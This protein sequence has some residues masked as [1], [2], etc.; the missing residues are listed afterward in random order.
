MKKLFLLLFVWTTSQAQTIWPSDTTPCNGS[1]SDC[2][3][4]SGDFGL[5]E[6]RT[7]DTINESIIAYNGISLI[8]GQG[9]KPHFG[10]GHSVEVSGNSGGVNRTVRFEGLRFSKGRIAYTTSNNGGS[11]NLII[12]DN[13]I[14]DNRYQ[15]TGIRIILSGA[16]TMNLDVSNNTI[17]FNTDEPVNHSGAISITNTF[18][19]TGVGTITG[20]VRENDI[21]LSGSTSVGIGV[22]ENL[23]F[24]SNLNIFANK[25]SGGAHG[26]YL[27]KPDTSTG[28]S[29]LNFGSNVMKRQSQAAFEANVEG[30]VLVLDV[31]NNTVVQSDQ[32]AFYIRSQNNADVDLNF[33]NN[34]AAFNQYPI[35]VSAT[36]SLAVDTQNGSNLFFGN[37]LSS[38]GFTPGTTHLTSDPQFYLDERIAQNS[39]AANTGNGLAVFFLPEVAKSIDADGS[40]RIKGTVDIGAYES[41]N[42]YFTHKVSGVPAHTNIIDSPVTNN[43]PNLKLQLTPNWNPNG[44]GGVYNNANQGVFYFSNHWRVFNQNLNSLP[45]DS[46]NNILVPAP[47]SAH[48]FTHIATDVSAP[49]LNATTLDI[50]GL[51]NNPQAILSV[52]QSWESVYNDSPIS[53]QYSELSNKWFIMNSDLQPMSLNAQFNVYFQEPS[54]NAYLHKATEDNTNLQATI[55][56][57]PLLNDTPCAQLQVTPYDNT[58][59]NAQAIGV[60]YN[61]A[62]WAIFNQNL[63]AM[64]LNTK[65]HVIVHEEQIAQCTDLIFADDFESS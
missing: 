48:A 12:K 35:S 29:E 31:I 32:Q 5:I 44:S 14:E 24:T 43:K 11:T 15:F 42:E 63:V 30:G 21:T 56:D 49:A 28:S 33:F 39:P 27:H 3:A 37:Q 45:T 54:A 62:R 64:P 7:N 16:Q 38:T 51:N 47:D 1:L 40:A 41:G 59:S 9:Y 19:N 8:A 10:A 52:T 34:I 36:G 22:Y 57:H 4:A 50:S 13:I 18:N 65:F 26:L 25:I 17:N 60:Y 2:V 6:I 20:V 53:I 46:A 23:A 61:G 58:P 55:L